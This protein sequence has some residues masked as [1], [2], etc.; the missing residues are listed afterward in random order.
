MKVE[1]VVEDIFHVTIQPNVELCK[2]FLRFQEHYE[3]PEFKG[4]IFTLLEFKEW[5]IADSENGK[6]TGNFTYY[7][8]WSGF[9]IPSHILDPFFEGS[10]N[11]L[12][13]REKDFLAKFEDKQDHDFYVVG[14]TGAKLD[15]LKHEVGHGL[16]YTRPDYRSKAEEIV[17]RIPENGRKGMEEFLLRIGYCDEVIL[18]ETHAFL[19]TNLDWLGKKGVDIEPLKGFDEE[20]QSNFRNFVGDKFD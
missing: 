15:Y 7:S 5:Y 13:W 1:E 6:K 4:K 19:L 16:F 11:P 9:N 14:T 12:S 10:F 18:D 3:S 8:D 2:T 20:L 17:S